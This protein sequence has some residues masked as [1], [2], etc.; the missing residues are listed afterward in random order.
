MKLKITA[1][2]YLKK[3]PFQITDIRVGAYLFTVAQE[4]EVTKLNF[5]E[6]NSH[7]SIGLLDGEVPWGNYAYIYKGHVN[8]PNSDVQP[9]GN[10]TGKST[11]MEGISLIKE[12][13]GC[14]L[15]SYLCPANVWTIG[16]G[17][18]K[19]AKKGQRIDLTHAE[20][21]LRGDL[22]GFERTVKASVKVPLSQNQFDAL[23]AFTY[24][25]GSRAF[26]DSTLLRKLNSEDYSGAADE[27]LRWD[28][29]GGRRL[30]GLTRRRI[31][32]RALFLR[33]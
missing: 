9:T 21:L 28:K 27:L 22:K 18:T 24:N 7:I 26:Q 4:I 33:M 29:G 16:Y 1:N 11:G 25:V 23:I 3:H 30:P 32:E 31:A 8:L 14:E 10:P 15:D 17:H 20:N 19:S 12:F 6:V 13:E 2:T 5:Q